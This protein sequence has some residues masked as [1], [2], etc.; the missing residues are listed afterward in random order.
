ML[1]VCGHGVGV[2]ITAAA[3]IRSQRQRGIDDQGERGVVVAVQRQADAAVL[4]ELVVGGDARLGAVAIVL[5]QGGSLLDQR[6]AGRGDQQLTRLVDGDALRPGPGQADLVDVG[7]GVDVQVEAQV[8][9]IAAVGDVD[10]GPDVVGHQLRV[11]GHIVDFDGTVA[12]AEVVAAAGEGL[13]G[14]EGDVGVGASEL[15]AEDVADGITGL[16]LAGVHIGGSGGVG[17]DA[18]LAGGDEGLVV[19]A[20]GQVEDVAVA[21]LTQVRLERQRQRVEGRQNLQDR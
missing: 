21:V 20:A 6:A 14:G 17:D 9:L 18:D 5:V 19:A 10:A 1:V 11:G 15:Q 13:L 4:A 12:A 16:S 3:R 2:I 8:L 7:A